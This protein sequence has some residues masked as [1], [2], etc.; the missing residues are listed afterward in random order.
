LVTKA[1]ES[2]VLLD[3]ELH[4]GRCIAKICRCEFYVHYVLLLSIGQFMV[5][6]PLLR[7]IPEASGPL[8]I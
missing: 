5:S 1:H 7:L 8:L 4:V 2:S 3:L 6:L